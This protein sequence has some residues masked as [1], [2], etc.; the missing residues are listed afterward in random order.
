MLQPLAPGHLRDVDQALNA[1]GDLDKSSVVS[2]ADHTAENAAENTAS[3]P[4]DIFAI[5]ERFDVRQ[6]PYVP[7]AGHSQL[8]ERVL[9]SAE[10]PEEALPWI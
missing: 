6:V 7:D 4:E 9:G 2:D 3:W 5:L 10:I 8:I 1:W